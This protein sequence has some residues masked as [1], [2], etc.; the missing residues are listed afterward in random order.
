MKKRK[1]LH[2]V[3]E[4]MEDILEM[5]LKK[6]N[7]I[8]EQTKLEL[9]EYQAARIHERNK[10]KH[11]EGLVKNGKF[12]PKAMTTAITQIDINIRQLADKIKL[13]KERI[14]HFTEIVTRLDA[15]LKNQYLGLKYLKEQRA[16]GIAN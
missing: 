11:Y 6:H 7:G 16:N 8:L 3:T 10:K 14:E 9:G 13:S 15:E 2:V 12:N 1:D 5:D 4:G